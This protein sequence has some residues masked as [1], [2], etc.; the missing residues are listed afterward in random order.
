M[1]ELPAPSGTPL[2]P[3]SSRQVPMFS[4][5]MQSYS[6]GGSEWV[7]GYPHPLEGQIIYE[8]D[9][10]LLGHDHHSLGG[11][12]ATGSCDAMGGCGGCD[13]CSGRSWRPCLTICLPEDGWVTMEYLGWFPRS[14]RVP[15]LATTSV[16]TG[17]PADQAGVLGRPATRVLYGDDVLF[18]GGVSGGRLQ[19]GLWLDPCHRWSAVGEYFEL[20]SQSD[21]FR[22]VSPG[23]PILARPFFNVLTG[24]EDSQLI[25]YPNLSSGQLDID[26]R[27]SFV[28][29]GFN[30][31][32]QTNCNSGV[33]WGSF[34]DPCSTFQSRTDVLFGYRYV[35]LDESILINE[36]LN[37]TSTPN[38]RFAIRDSFRTFNQF[39]G[40]D[41][42][43]TYER[44]RGLWSVDVLA[45]MA[46]GNTRQRVDIDGSTLI[47]GAPQTGGGLLAQSSN[48][49]SYTRDQFT[50]MPELGANLGY[51]L[52]DHLRLKLGYTLIFWS[53]V[54]RPGD[55]IDLDLNPNQF[56]PA[57][58][59]GAPRPRFEFRDSDF[60]VQGIN[61]GGEFSW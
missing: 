35:Q 42:G 5:P 18:D 24:R 14:M 22:S 10:H 27:S 51:D 20:Q 41:M 25:A 39:N 57:I 12:A 16:G 17:V 52:T 21:S 47:N 38:N 48:I 4:G 29:G 40:F 55:Q 26:V 36:V 50:I 53:N 34:G 54:V 19:V 59:G 15:A 11:F 32:R 28:G 13:S 23:T 43:V 49:N 61:F 56:P 1:E 6:M 8:G 37:Q 44:R 7:D 31:R 30:F 3:G 58:P 33:G 9:G 60:W 46:I 2:P 45:K